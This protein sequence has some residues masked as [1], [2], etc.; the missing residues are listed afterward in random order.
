MS[1]DGPRPAKIFLIH[2]REHQRH[3]S[4][5]VDARSYQNLFLSVAVIICFK[6]S[7]CKIQTLEGL[8]R[9]SRL[10]ESNQGTI[11]IP[12]Y[13]NRNSKHLS[14]RNKNKIEN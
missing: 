13:C 1:S 6:G 3:S 9:L 12:L 4:D 5:C 11:I 2:L 7:V 8:L 14:R 10:L